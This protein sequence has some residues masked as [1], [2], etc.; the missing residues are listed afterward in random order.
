M[1]AELR[2]SRASRC[3]ITRSALS[4]SISSLEFVGASRPDLRAIPVADPAV[5]WTLAAIADRHHA[6][7][8]TRALIAVLPEVRTV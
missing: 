4:A 2:R 6:T 8:A 1:S 5:T 3:H 7:P